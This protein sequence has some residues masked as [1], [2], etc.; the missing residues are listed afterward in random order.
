MPNMKINIEPFTL[1]LLINL[2]SHDSPFN[3]LLLTVHYLEL[4]VVASWHEAR[5][6]MTMRVT[7]MY[8]RQGWMLRFGY[9]YNVTI[10]PVMMAPVTYAAGKGHYQDSK[11]YC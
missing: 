6:M 11:Y 7:R 9:N 4:V 8:R 1:I 5:S 10:M 3:I 2:N